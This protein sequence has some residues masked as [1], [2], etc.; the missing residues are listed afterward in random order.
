MDN[1]TLPDA[2]DDVHFDEVNR[3]EV[4]SNAARAAWQLAVDEHNNRLAA[5]AKEKKLTTDDVFGENRLRDDLKEW[6]ADW[7]K[8]DLGRECRDANGKIDFFREYDDTCWDNA[9]LIIDALLPLVIEMY[10]GQYGGNVVG[11]VDWLRQKTL[12][13]DQYIKEGDYR[14]AGSCITAGEGFDN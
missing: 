1:T 9:D 2:A 13:F 5:L 3:N 4:N 10:D 12:L 11:G 7:F 8:K 14:G 6:L